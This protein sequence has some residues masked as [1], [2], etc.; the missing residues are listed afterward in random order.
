MGDEEARRIAEK[1]ADWIWNNAG[2]DKEDETWLGYY[3]TG[4]KQVLERVIQERI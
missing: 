2:L 1:I 3:H 4:A